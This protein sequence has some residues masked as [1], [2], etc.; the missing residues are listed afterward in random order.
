MVLVFQGRTFLQ[1][2]DVCFVRR[3]LGVFQ[4][5]TCEC[6]VLVGYSGREVK[7]GVR[8]ALF[9]WPGPCGT[10]ELWVESNVSARVWSGKR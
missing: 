5:F 1:R 3:W 4:F 9:M 7:I 2:E 8:G 6:E 10:R